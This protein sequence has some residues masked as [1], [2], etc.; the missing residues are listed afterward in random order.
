[1]CQTRRKIKSDSLF[2]EGESVLFEN[3][4]GYFS[5]SGKEY[6][7]T[8]P[9]TP[10]PWRNYISNG[11]YGFEI[12]QNG[13]GFSWVKNPEYCRLTAS[14]RGLDQNKGKYFYVRDRKTGHF[15][16]MTDQPTQTP[17]ERCE[18]R[19]G[20]GYTIFARQ[21][22][23]IL[24]EMKM[25]VVPEKP[26][27]ILEVK[28]TN[29]SNF[30]QDLDL[31][32]YI[33]W[34]GFDGKTAPDAFDEMLCNT[35]FD[36]LMNA[37]KH[38]F[39]LW[40]T[41]PSGDSFRSENTAMLHF[42]AVSE[43]PLA[44]ETDQTSFLGLYGCLCDP[45][46]LKSKVLAKNEGRFV[47]PIAS[48]QN[49]LSL[50]PSE[51]KT[52]I[53]T[54][55][56]VF[57]SQS[58]AMEENVNDLIRKYNTVEGAKAAFLAVNALWN[59]LL[60]GDEARTPNPGFDL[61]INHFAK[62]Q[63][64]S[65]NLWTPEPKRAT[66]LSLSALH[67][68]QDAMIFL[69]G[70]P[71]Q[72]RNELLKWVKNPSGEIPLWFPYVLDAYLAETLDFSLLLEKVFDHKEES[73]TLY[74][75]GKRVI[76]NALQRFQSK[77]VSA[78]DF[79]DQVDESALTQSAFRG[80]SVFFACLLISVLTRFQRS[81]RRMQ[82]SDLI[83]EMQNKAIQLRKWV[84][85]SGWDG[86]WLLSGITQSGQKIGS[87]ESPFGQIFLL[88]NVWGIL[89]E[90]LPPE[91]QKSVVNFIESKLLCEFGLRLLS[92]GYSS[93]DPDLGLFTFYPPGFRENG[94]FSTLFSAWAIS[95]CIKSDK[96]DLAWQTYNRISP[97]YRIQDP[98]HYRSEP[99]LLSDFLDAPE[100]PQGGRG[101]GMGKTATAQWLYHIAVTDLIGVKATYEGLSIDPHVPSDWK[102]FF[103]RRKFRTAVYE[104][105]FTR[106]K[107]FRIIADGKT[108]SG[109]LIPDFKME[110]PIRSKLP[111]HKNGSRFVGCHFSILF[112]HSI[113]TKVDQAHRESLWGLLH[114]LF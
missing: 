56:S 90:S 73:I 26:L 48:F 109:K 18:I 107:N 61:L 19:H 72:T 36:P 92:P 17:F 11:I 81:A 27:E 47:Q 78:I 38:Q 13:N 41:P 112:P 45:L 33:E 80:E 95:A 24:S 110:K 10:A 49:R 23:S 1:M 91:R 74:Q 106:G 53:Y 52:L 57:S 100:S 15:W 67:P 34:N 101:R 97:L 66:S 77:Q 2:C 4:Y 44:F 39:P 104:C 14:S 32:S 16:S 42:H 50:N 75:H 58:K 7:I 85:E 99:Y 94:G 22:E 69:A 54:I 87:I 98:D 20:I 35:R 70:S 6:I 21:T 3:K 79:P 55:G 96:V 108:I 46:A 37:I 82:D 89:S 31:I 86:E 60:S 113:W 84:N 29:R 103:Y 105:S 12:A 5:E 76:Q 43:A 93:P 30:A 83:R 102:Q 114:T 40:K 65:A 63:A 62:Y 25:F 68:L 88:P 64:I 9:R 111:L 51:S 59:E 28:I 8:D 71:D